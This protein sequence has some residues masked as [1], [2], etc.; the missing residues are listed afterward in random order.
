MR[1]QKFLAEAG[2]CSRRKAEE[3]ITKGLVKVNG[4]VVK[5]L[6]TKI[7]PDKD[8]I[9]FR[10]RK[11]KLQDKIYFMLNKPT[12][13]VTTTHDQFNRPNVTELGRINKRI[14]PIGRLDYDTS[15][16]LILTNDGDLAY[17]L[18][19]PKH[20]VN[21]IYLAKIKGVPSKNE[22]SNFEKGL[23]IDNSYV[24]A[25]AQIKI[26][27]SGKSFS[28]AQIIIHEG[29]NRQIRKM[30]AEINHPV[31]EL[32][33]I[34]IGNLKLDVQEGKYRALKKCEVDYLKSI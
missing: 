21:K 27:Q 12:G 9:S 17:K 4:N 22:L 23:L 2:V 28:L 30:C 32:K 33:R 31:V 8:I 7:F 29:K 19:H 25:K 11:L 15:G 34:A 10:E 1:L 16:L 26:L 5:Q 20:N 6:G 24:T 14:F 18:T 13:Y 3:L